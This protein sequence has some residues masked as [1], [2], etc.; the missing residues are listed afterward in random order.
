MEAINIKPGERLTR[1]RYGERYSLG[2]PCEERNSSHGL[3]QRKGLAFD[4]L[5]AAYSA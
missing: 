3:T 5:T 1:N 4:G 2:R